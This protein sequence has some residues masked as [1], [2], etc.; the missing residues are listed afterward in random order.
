MFDAPIDAWYVWFG[1]AV[2]AATMLGLAGSL[3]A[4]A[5]PDAPAAANVVDSVAAADDPTTGEAPLDAAE[6]RLGPHRVGLRRDGSAAHAS[7]AFGPVT[8]V[9][10]GSRLQRVL[11][12][13][14][15]GRLFDSPEAFRQAVVDARTREPTWR[16]VDRT[17]VVRRLSWE[18]IDVTLVDA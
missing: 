5:P 12:G 14:S 1:T 16:P 13:T 11:Y 3:P 2:A 8:P 6:V 7:F 15:P 9:T 10:E 18:G 17:L 4:T